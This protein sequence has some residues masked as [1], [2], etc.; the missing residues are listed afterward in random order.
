[1]LGAAAHELARSG[2]PALRIEDVAKRAKVHK[3][4]V[5]RRWPSKARL[6]GAML[7]Q[8]GSLASEP[9]DTGSIH[10]DLLALCETLVTLASSPVGRAVARLVSTDL[11]DPE[12]HK[13]IRVQRAKQEAPWLAVIERAIVRGELRAGTNA[14]LFTEVL[15]S[16]IFSR[17]FRRRQPADPEF[18]RDLVGLL[19]GQA[20]PGSPPAASARA[21]LG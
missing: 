1:M 15:R 21:G 5:Y 8:Y 7:A 13:V 6:M 12:V 16:T 11:D 2:Y 17:L 3:T 9:P 14:P 18:L 10:G 20:M 4:T 19:L